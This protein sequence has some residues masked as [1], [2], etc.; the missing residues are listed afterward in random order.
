VVVVRGC[1]RPVE[2]KLITTYRRLY[3]VRLS[4]EPF[5][6]RWAESFLFAGSSSLLLLIARMFPHYWFFSLFALTPFLYKI[7]ISTPKESLRLGFLFGLSFFGA[8]L[9]HSFIAA[10]TVCLPT[11]TAGTILFSLFGWAAG[12]ARSRWG[13]SPFIVAVLWVGLEMG[14]LRF[15]FVDGI[16]VESGMASPLLHGLVGLLGFLAVSALIVLL[17]SFLI[18]A[19]L[20]TLERVSRRGKVSKENQSRRGAISAWSPF[21]E[22]AYLVPEDRAPP[23]FTQSFRCCFLVVKCLGRIN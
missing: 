21:T 2:R 1:L 6:L 23:L 18:L 12:W 20:K 22:K 16:L 19:V 8:S 7:I 10:P 11:L 5:L 17:N 3:P 9:G 4:S 15:G 13:F 14:L